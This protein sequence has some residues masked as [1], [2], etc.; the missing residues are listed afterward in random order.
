MAIKETVQIDV[1]TNADKAADDLTSAIRDLQKAVEQMSTSMNDGFSEANQNISKVD[2]GIKDV[3]DSAKDSAKSTGKLGKAFG[4]LGKT[5][6]IF[7]IIDGALSIIKDLFME[8]QI[9]VDAFNTVFEFLSIAVNDFINF[10]VG[11]TDKVVGFFK[12]IFDDPKQAMIDFKDAF[13]ENIIERFNSFLD[14]LGFIASAV[15][16]VFSGD[17]KGALDDVKNAGKEV[18]D[19]FTG[20]DGSFDKA[21]EATSK[22]V[23]ETAKAASENVKLAKAAELADVKRQG[24]LEKYDLEAEKLRQIRD[25]E[26]NT[27]EERIQANK[28]LGDVLDKQEKEML[29]QAQ[30][31]LD[32][33]QKEA[34]KKKGNL[35]AEKALIEAKNEMAG[36][37]AQITGMR[38]EQLSNEEALLRES[39]ELTRGKAEAEQEAAQMEKQALIDAE[40][41]VLKRI[42]L[43]KELAEEVKKG[44]IGLIDEEL[45]TTKE[46]TLRYQELLNERLLAEAEYQA[47]SK[48]LDKE[49]E[50]EKLVRRQESQAAYTQIASQGFDALFALSEAFAGDSEEQQRRAFGVQ[51]ALSMANTVIGTYEAAQNAFT[52]AQKSPITAVNPAYPY[53][54]A[55][56]ATAFGV[57]KLAS[58]ARTK[59]DS[60][61]QPSPDSDSGGAPSAMI[62]QFNVVGASGTNVIAQSLQQQGPVRAYVVG[63]DVTSQQELDRRRINNTSL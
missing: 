54:Q 47:E 29:A 59:F 17:F 5:S 24:L 35:E 34:D 62:P 11:N 37:E 63:S 12:S 14:T 26:R 61:S 20:V 32:L 41:D 25:S 39:L 50:D 42:E 1:D 48:R 58:I 31:R 40:I 8:N 49:T 9:A 60:S 15:K 16:K 36:I 6:G 28:D 10:I 7:F 53:I 46:G 52:T 51:K 45:A 56:L 38:A 18:V 44:R 27:L 55:G 3:G 19:V 23:K 57:A 43:E 4:N 21:A 22:Y 30:I 13:V 2:E 33:A